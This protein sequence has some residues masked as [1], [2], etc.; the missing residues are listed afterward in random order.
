MPKSYVAKLLVFNYIRLMAGAPPV[1]LS[2]AGF[3]PGSGAGVT[4][5]L[6]TTAA[7]GCYGIS[8]ITALTVQNTVA[9]KAVEPVAGRLV[10]ATLDA[11]AEDFEIRAVRIGML[12]TA[13]VAHV[14]ADYL[15][16]NRP[17]R[18]VLDPV[19]H[20]SS[21]AVLLGESGVEVLRDRLLRMATVV[22][23]NLAEAGILTRSMVEGIAGIRQAAEQLQNLGAK[24]VVIT[25]GHLAG[26][27]D[28]LRLE[29]GEVQEIAGEKID[30]KAT[31]GT[32]CAYAT[33]LACNLANGRSVLESCRASKKFVAEAIAAA[34]PVG[35]GHGP[36]NH[37]FHR[38]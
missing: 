11:L 26:N 28:V 32:G 29:S 30:S 1:V 35:Q 31:H 4:G 37:L 10:G 13:E 20:S 38:G 16:R 22:T 19:I 5:D 24:N 36:L 7:H 14:V 6:K 8:A 12:G 3:D 17:E 25:G 18:V 15:E 33:A 34:Y 23:P 9:V 21:G 27:T 2:I